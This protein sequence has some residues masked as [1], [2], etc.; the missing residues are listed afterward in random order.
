[1]SSRM[2]APT[3]ASAQALQLVD[4]VRDDPAGRRSLM[5]S[6]HEDDPALPM[7]TTLTSSPSRFR[8]RRAA[9]AFMDW[10]IRRGLLAP[11][12]GSPWWRAVNES[13]LR[14]IA[15]ARALASGAAGEPSDPQVGFGV[16]FIRSPSARTWYRA[17]NASV[18]AAYLR[19]ADTAAAETRAERFFINLV[20]VRV[21]Y[22]HALVASPRMALGWCHRLSPLLGDPGLG[23]TGIF[24]SLSRV[25]PDRYP[26]RGPLETY[27]AAEHGVGRLLD[28]GMIIPRL[29]D[30]YSWSAA[31][32]RQPRLTDLLTDGVPS[33]AWPATD[34]GPWSPPPTP[35]IR[36][37]RRVVPAQTG[38]VC[39]RC[40]GTP[41]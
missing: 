14:D 23:M 30:L 27:T 18:V 33:Y 28:V 1:M 8:Y 17:H 15:E 24:L 16:E 2:Q 21:L 13:L 29:Q 12:S 3:A 32:L 34:P 5:M 31:E 20:L 39:G 9:L 41:G 10:Q 35:L 26:L 7:L 36:L 6:L 19:H 38:Q 37:A 25:L 11:G 22:A 4:A 40:V